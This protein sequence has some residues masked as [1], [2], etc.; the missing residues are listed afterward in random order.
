VTPTQVLQLTPAPAAAGA[1]APPAA[2][3][4]PSELTP[5]PPP[6]ASPRAV[7]GSGA[8]S[9]G[10]PPSFVPATTPASAPAPAPSPAAGGPAPP[11]PAAAAAAAA[12]ANLRE[13]ARAAATAQQAP[14]RLHILTTQIHQD[15]QEQGQ[16]KG[17]DGAGGPASILE[18]SPHAA[19]LP[20]HQTSLFA[21]LG[22]LAPPAAAA[23][24]AGRGSSSPALA[25]GSP[26]PRP[27]ETSLEEALSAQSPFASLAQRGFSPSAS[28]EAA[29]QAR[30]PSAAE[31]HLGSWVEVAAKGEAGGAASTGAEGYRAPQPPPSPWT[32]AMLR[33][34]TH[35]MYARP[36]AR[37]AP[38]SCLG[39]FL[40]KQCMHG[41]P[42]ALTRPRLRR[43]RGC[44]PQ[45]GDA[46]WRL[47]D[48]S[49]SCPETSP[50][51]ARPV[52]CPPSFPTQVHPT[53]R[54]EATFAKLPPDT[55]FF[56]FHFHQGTRQQV[57]AANALKA[58]G[59]RYHT[60]FHA[61]FA[62][63]G[64][65]KVVTES[66]EQGSLMFWDAALHGDGGVAAP[67][68]GAPAAGWGPHLSRGDFVFSYDCIE[69]ESTSAVSDPA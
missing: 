55:A 45:H 12:E 16:G 47:H 34:G 52:I 17:W 32:T 35:H 23:D 7:L 57:W 46:E 62:R 30:P 33:A 65:P 40:P 36:C 10:T 21:R 68:G 54:Q 19:P 56:A 29:A 66:Y 5:P 43:A 1:A 48:G 4:R 60:Q 53:L 41:L 22:A 61:W 49:L 6:P 2:A 20:P 13:A 37:L 69:N 51:P 31:W 3:P 64:Q 38:A 58:Q 24:S 8:P 63:Q 9:T 44:R 27:Q 26:V 11:S 67:G 42:A 25:P 18:A 15:E 39:C 28:Q 50:R 59:W 14:H